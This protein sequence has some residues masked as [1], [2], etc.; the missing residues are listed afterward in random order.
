MMTILN[1]LR[2]V[3]ISFI[4]IASLFFLVVNCS[5]TENISEEETIDPNGN[6]EEVAIYAC[7][8]YTSDAADE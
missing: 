6:N 4:A 7:L 2:A 8:L 5:S 1:K 3:L